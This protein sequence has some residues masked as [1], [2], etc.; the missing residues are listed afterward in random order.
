MS[1]LQRR[2][3]TIAAAFA[4]A[5]LVSL[6][7]AL[8]AFA[9]PGDTSLVSVD[10]AGNQGDGFSAGPALSADGRFVA[11]SSSATNLVPGDTNGLTDVF[12]RDRQTG[13]TERVSVSSTGG[14]ADQSSRSPSISADGRY[15]SFDS[16][17]SNLV[18]G[19]TNGFLDVFVHD[20]QTGTT[21]RVSVDSAGN[22]G[23][24]HSFSSYYHASLSADG[25][26]VA[27]E[28]GASNLVPDDTNATQDVFVHDLQT[29]NTE[30]VS[31]DD[32]GIEADGYSGN[33]VAI[34]PDGRYVGFESFASNLFPPVNGNPYLVAHDRQTGTNERVDVS[35]DG[36]AANACGTCGIGS[37]S[38]DDRYV[39]FFSRAQNLVPGDSNDEDIYVRDRQAGT[40]ELVSVDS[41][42]NQSSVF[43][44][45][46]FASM[47]GDG[48]YVAWSTA[49]PYLVPDDTTNG[50]WDVFVHDRQTGVTER[51]D[52]DSAGNAPNGSSE[53]PAI[54]ADGRF[55]GF[56]SAASNLVAG[57]ANGQYDVF[58]H[59]LGEPAPPI[60]S[61]HA[62]V[63][64]G[65]TASTNSTTSPSDPVGTSVTTPT[66]GVVTI[67][68]GATT[69]PD[70]AGYSLLGREVQIT[71]PDETSADPLV[72]RF[73]LDAS[74][75][76]PGATPADVQV[77]RDG[78]VMPDCDAGAG[79]SASPDPCVAGRAA[80]ANGIELT[81]RT[82]QA[83]TWN[84]GTS[85]VDTA[86]PETTITS[87]PSGKTNDATPTFSFSSSEAGSTF[88]CRVDGAAFTPCSSPNTLVS[89]SEG[90]HTF[91]VRATDA[92]GNTDPTP[93]VRIFIVDTHAPN[94]TITA[95][96][97]GQTNDATPTFSFSSSEAGSTFECRVDG[98]AFT[99]CSSPTTLAA[100][101]DGSHTF[102]VRATD[103][104]GNTDNSPA[105]RSFTVD[106]H[107]PETT[108]TAGPSGNTRDRTPTF[109]FSSSEPTGASF[110]C[111]LDGAAFSPCSSPKKLATLAFGS[112]TFRVR[113]ID[114]AGNVDPT[115][116]TRTFTVTH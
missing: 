75:L 71:A 86:P 3:P 90:T 26:F 115:P 76:P 46:H 23:N 37:F 59:E 53:D 8:T 35:S 69:T 33:G 96:P 67:A 70:P 80:T 60:D 58:V 104:A 88:E 102:R 106:T 65:G 47:S 5:V 28:S 43:A 13:T 15:V 12:V 36:T 91:T 109:R 94:T 77:F 50:T 93:A 45:S 18:D 95:G 55:V 34:S 108:I 30:R 14:E 107:A 92:A 113:A 62:R 40:T 72:L 85:N 2:R 105:V 68:E 63:A 114:A 110:E 7:L 78:V 27:F 6:A 25:R 51:V 56:D 39:A 9:S 81:V 97:S 4:V 64:A 38:S 116:A 89:Q 73:R 87:G 49:V 11:F 101:S 17:A 84:F 48:R 41:A 100:Q 74:I 42:G 99:P 32:A 103:Q 21:E 16:T 111:R 83:S 1:S 19:D 98:A 79:S 54:S 66:G 82:S 61:A 44:H 52:V 20:R 57:D 29:G 24:D 112:H 31:L 10:S 22:E